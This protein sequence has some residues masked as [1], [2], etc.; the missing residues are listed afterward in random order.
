[1]DLPADGIGAEQA[2]VAGGRGNIEREAAGG[3]R[4]ATDLV[5]D[6]FAQRCKRGGHG[7][8]WGRTA[9]EVDAFILPSRPHPL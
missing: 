4:Q 7:A 1:M 2:R 9:G 8:E 3:A 5:G 6:A